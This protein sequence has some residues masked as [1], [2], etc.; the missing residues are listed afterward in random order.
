[1]L[2]VLSRLEV[3]FIHSTGFVDFETNKTPWGVSHA[4]HGDRRTF[5]ALELE[6]LAKVLNIPRQSPAADIDRADIKLAQ[7]RRNLLHVPG[8]RRGNS[9]CPGKRRRY[10]VIG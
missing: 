2:I 3:R 5:R 1:M 8:H 10:R 6:A 4:S 9:Q 7:S